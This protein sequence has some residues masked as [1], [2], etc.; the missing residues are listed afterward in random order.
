MGFLTHFRY[1]QH[2]ELQLV[3]LSALRLIAPGPCIASTP[4]DH[5]LHPDKMLFKRIVYL[6]ILS[7]LSP[8][9]LLYIYSFPPFQFY[10]YKHADIHKIRL[11]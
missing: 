7:P 1:F 9:P 2:T 5:I 3:A 8:L 11:L 4:P 10:F 6:I